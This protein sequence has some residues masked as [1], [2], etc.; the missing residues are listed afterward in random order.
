MSRP[1]LLDLYHRAGFDVIGVDIAPQPR[2][3]FAFVQADALDYVFDCVDEHLGRCWGDLAA[4]HASPP[5]QA[6]S[7]GTV[8][9]D[10][11]RYPDLIPATRELLQHSGLPYVIENVPRAPLIDPVVACGAAFDL[12]VAEATREDEGPPYGRWL[13]LRRHRLFES[14]VAL[15]LPPCKCKH[16]RE[17]G[18]VVGGV[19]GGGSRPWSERA[20][21]ATAATRRI[22][23]INGR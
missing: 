6:H 16:Y 7:H 12:V 15:A 5:C 8:A 23:T 4:I 19:Y 9:I 21:C 10:R 3:P 18:Y 13:V 2:Y 1:L 22:S 11:S 14:N 20:P 17:K